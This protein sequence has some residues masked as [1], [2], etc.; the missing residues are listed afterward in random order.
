MSFKSLT[1]CILLCV[2]LIKTDPVPYKDCGMILSNPISLY[3]Q[4]IKKK[5]LKAQIQELK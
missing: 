4:I 2:A 5:L 1:Y 3:N